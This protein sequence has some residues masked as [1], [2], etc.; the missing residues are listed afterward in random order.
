MRSP[1]SSTKVIDQNTVDYPP[2]RFLNEPTDVLAIS[3]QTRTL[4]E[5]ERIK[6]EYLKK[7]P[8]SQVKTVSTAIDIQCCY[9]YLEWQNGISFKKEFGDEY[10]FPD[11][12]LFDSFQIFEKN[13]RSGDWKYAIMTSLGCPYSCDYCMCKNREWKVRSAG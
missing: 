8:K 3:V 13:W 6:K 10:P 2:D 1:F 5:A 4:K 7:Y 11:Y 9:P 12:E